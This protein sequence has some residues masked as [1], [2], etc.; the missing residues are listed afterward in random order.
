MNVNLDALKAEYSKLQTDHAA[1]AR[2]MEQVQAELK[3]LN[4]IRY[5]VSQVLG[6]EQVAAMDK[7]EGKQS[8]VEQLHQTR[9]RTEK[10]K[11]KIWSSRYLY[12]KMNQG[13]RS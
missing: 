1:F 12:E 7:A 8:V 3:P 2:Q 10:K 4:E 6:A 11:N 9:E 5:W 13:Y